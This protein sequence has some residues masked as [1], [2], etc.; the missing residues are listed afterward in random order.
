MQIIYDLTH[1]VLWE[2]L[3]IIRE[4]PTLEHIVDIGPHC[5]KRDASRRIIGDNVR[6][7]DEISK[8]GKKV[9]KVNPIGQRRRNTFVSVT[10]LVKSE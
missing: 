7:V 1:S 9:G 8:Q 6:N 10:T 2:V 5:F 3:G 4:N